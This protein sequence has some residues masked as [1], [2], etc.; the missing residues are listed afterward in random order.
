M[1]SF[2]KTA[3]L[4]LFGLI[5]LLAFPLTASASSTFQAV[6]AGFFASADATASAGTLVRKSGEARG[7]AQNGKGPPGHGSI[8]LRLALTGLDAN[9]SYSIWWIIF[10]V[11]NPCIADG[12][13]E[14]SVPDGV[15]N[16]GGFVTGAD[17]TANMTAELDVGP[18][19]TGNVFF[20]ALMDSFRDEIHIVIQSHGDYEPG[21]V[22]EQISIA[23]AFCNLDDCGL[24]DQQFVVFPPMMP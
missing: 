16:A 11:G 8:S 17:G 13:N 4:A 24:A 22:A 2:R 21:H 19:S 5:A 1:K 15:V 23:G 20:G 12:C 6:N 14:S 10:N 9:A 3:I 18:L 7:R